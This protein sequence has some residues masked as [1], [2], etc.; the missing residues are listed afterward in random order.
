MGGWLV[1]T[2]N[3]A[4]SWQLYS[5]ASLEHQATSTMTC[6]ANQLHYP[7][8]EPSSHCPI[9]IMPS[10]RLGSDKYQ[11]ESHW[12]DLTRVRKLRG[13]DSKPRPSGSLI[14]QNV[15][16]VLYSFG[17][18]DWF[19]A[20]VSYLASFR[21][22]CYGLCRFIHCLFCDLLYGLIVGLLLMFCPFMHSCLRCG[23]ISD[24]LSL[25]FLTLSLLW[26][27]YYVVCPRSME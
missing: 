21:V 22:S 9:L 2:C 19:S 17:H 15:R 8:V 27:V 26:S 20:V 12:F 24:L 1:L 25:S 14:F 13:S 6:Y 16:W 3:S 7:D 18:P 4:H 23:L 11:F 10:T 5:A